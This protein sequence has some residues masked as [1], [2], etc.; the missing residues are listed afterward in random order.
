M[1]VSRNSNLGCTRSLIRWISE[2]YRDGITSEELEEK[3]AN[4]TLL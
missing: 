1:D 4:R 3:S 2:G